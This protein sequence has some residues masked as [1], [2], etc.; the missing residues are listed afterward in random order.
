MSR[1]P[2]KKSRKM[3][4]PRIASPVTIPR[5]CWTGCP[6]TALVVVTIIARLLLYYSA[7]DRARLLAPNSRAHHV[8]NRPAGRDSA[9]LS[10][11]RAVAPIA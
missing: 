9:D 8:R 6:S 7:T 10:R 2:A 11:T 3:L 1:M 4:A 5:Y